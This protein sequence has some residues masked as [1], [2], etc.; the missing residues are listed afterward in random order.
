MI[1]GNYADIDWVP[2]RYLNRAFDRA[3]LMASSA[4]PR[5]DW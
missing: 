4:K 3:T 1:N 2:I 5:L